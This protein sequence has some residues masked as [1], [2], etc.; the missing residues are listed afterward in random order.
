L[1]IVELDGSAIVP[2]AQHSAPYW[3]DSTQGE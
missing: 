1:S 3:P 2:A